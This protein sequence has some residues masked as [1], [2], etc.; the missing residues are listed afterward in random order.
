MSD[1]STFYSFPG[2]KTTKQV[3]EAWLFPMTGLSH[4]D[5]QRKLRNQSKSG[6]A[7][8]CLSNW[9]PRLVFDP[10]DE[11]EC[12]GTTLAMGDTFVAC[13]PFAAVEACDARR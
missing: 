7:G 4:E 10:V 5:I 1:L 9:E 6:L 13:D 3:S 2:L 12:L 11:F 8:K